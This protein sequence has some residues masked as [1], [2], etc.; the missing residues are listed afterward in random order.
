[1]SDTGP[2]TS[3]PSGGHHIRTEVRNA[4]TSPSQLTYH[5]SCTCGWHSTACKDVHQASQQA[6]AH[7]AM[8]TAARS[9]ND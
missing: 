1:L 8:H 5:A 6:A 3:D 9:G 4:G 2:T 7:L